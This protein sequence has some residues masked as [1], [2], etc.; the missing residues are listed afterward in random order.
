MVPS[1]MSDVYASKPTTLVTVTSWVQVWEGMMSCCFLWL[2]CSGA[3]IVKAGHSMRPSNQAKAWYE[4]ICGSKKGI[5]KI[6]RFIKWTT[7]TLQK[8]STYWSACINPRDTTYRRVSNTQVAQLKREPH[9]LWTWKAFVCVWFIVV[10][11]DLIVALF[12]YVLCSLPEA[13]DDVDPSKN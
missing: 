1:H 13:H 7:G 3:D 12:I 4:D 6:M 10:A 8:S 11:P 2:A 9:R 5:H